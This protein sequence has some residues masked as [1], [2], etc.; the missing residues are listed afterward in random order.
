MISRDEN[1]NEKQKESKRKNGLDKNYKEYCLKQEPSSYWAF[2][3]LKETKLN[4][5]FESN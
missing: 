1:L 4:F 2:L 3:K 5:T